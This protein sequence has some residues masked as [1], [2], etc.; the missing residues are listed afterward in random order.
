MFRLLLNDREPI[1]TEL[2]FRLDWQELPHRDACRIAYF[3]EDV[4]PKDETRWPEFRRW[5]IDRLHKLERTFRERIRRLSADNCVPSD[6]Q[7]SDS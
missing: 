1:E 3:L 4:D 5:M 7:I 2:G 6:E